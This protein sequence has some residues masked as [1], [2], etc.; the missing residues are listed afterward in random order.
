MLYKLV[1]FLSFSFF[2]SQT[3]GPLRQQA[4]FIQTGPISHGHFAYQLPDKLI[5]YVLRFFK[6]DTTFTHI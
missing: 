5:G 2:P 6:A 4:L 3:S 1:G